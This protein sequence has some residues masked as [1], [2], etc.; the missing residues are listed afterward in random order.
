L[1]G[2]SQSIGRQNTGILLFKQG[3]FIIRVFSEK[4]NALH[5]EE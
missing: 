3:E 5:G 1:F 2:A 4:E